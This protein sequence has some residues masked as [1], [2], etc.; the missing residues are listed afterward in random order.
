MVIAVIIG[1]VTPPMA[2]ALVISGR[3][4]DVDQL[5]VFRANLPFLWGM[6]GFLLLIMAIPELATW[7][8]SIVRE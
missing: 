1:Q 4:A 8:P 5:Q 2:I 6:L 3:L 7:L